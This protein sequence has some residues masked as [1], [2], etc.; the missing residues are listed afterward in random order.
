MPQL[1]FDRLAQRGINLVAQIPTANLP[2]Q[3]APAFADLPPGGTLLLFGMGGAG[4]WQVAQ[5]SWPQEAQPIDFLSR[6]WTTEAAQAL[7][8]KDPTPLFPGGARPR[9]LV[10]LALLARFGYRS[11]LGI[12]IHPEYG[13]WTAI[14]ALL[15]TSDPLPQSSPELEANPCLSCLDRPCLD[16]C[17]AQAPRWEAAFGLEDC[18]TYRTQDQSPCARGCLSR[19]D[20]PV[21]A[22]H[23]YPK[24]QRD[25]SGSISLAT[26][27]AWKKDREKAP[28]GQTPDQ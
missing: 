11:P 8:L 14:R 9:P 26:L 2:L 28:A 4:F 10:D 1:G 16:G 15:W 3:L 19:L 22:A 25:Y 6:L 20:C 27:Q 18:I 24:A 13:L 23:R 21:G 17:P 5:A 12:T 7:G